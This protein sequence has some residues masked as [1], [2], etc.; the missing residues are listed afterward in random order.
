MNPSCGSLV[1]LGDSLGVEVS[2]NLFMNYGEIHRDVPLHIFNALT[3]AVKLTDNEDFRQPFC[4][5]K[6]NSKGKI[7]SF[8]KKCLVAKLLCLLSDK[9]EDSV[10]S[11]LERKLGGQRKGSMRKVLV[12]YEKDFAHVY[13]FKKGQLSPQFHY[14]EWNVFGFPMHSCMFNFS[15]NVPYNNDVFS[16]YRRTQYIDNPLCSNLSEL[17]RGT[18]KLEQTS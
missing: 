11:L 8:T 9:S 15:N 2:G 3:R 7:V 13:N 5:V 4:H 14:V 16:W 12:S 18:A 17:I 10:S 1:Y 6:E